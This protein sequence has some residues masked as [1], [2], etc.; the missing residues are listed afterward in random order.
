[1]EKVTFKQFFTTLGAAT[2]VATRTRVFMVS[3]SREYSQ[4]V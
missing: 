1:M 4:D 3:S 2:S